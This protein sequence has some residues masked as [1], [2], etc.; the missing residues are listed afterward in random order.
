MRKTLATFLIASLCAGALA[1]NTIKTKIS[2]Q[3]QAQPRNLA[4]KEEITKENNVLA[5][6]GYDD[7]HSDSATV[8]VVGTSSDS[9]SS[10][11]SGDCCCFKELPCLGC[12]TVKSAE[13]KTE[14]FKE[15]E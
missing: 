11:G 15:L 14:C 1:G 5:D 10:S 12:G 6:K 2:H 8:V 7:S 3:S 4:Q 9:G 13:C